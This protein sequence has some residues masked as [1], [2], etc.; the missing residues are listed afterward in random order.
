MNGNVELDGNAMIEDC[1]LDRYREALM[2][3]ANLDGAQYVYNVRTDEFGRMCVDY[4]PVARI[5]ITVQTLSD[6][7]R[8]ALYGTATSANVEGKR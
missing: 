8:N 1:T 4:S 5:N 7:A 2:R 3:I 6:I